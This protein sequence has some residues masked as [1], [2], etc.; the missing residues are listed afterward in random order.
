MDLRLVSRLLGFVALFV[1]V[2]MVF[3]TPWA[4]PLFGA[5]PKFESAGFFG[6]LG[7]IAVSLGSAGVLWRLGQGNKGKLYRKEAM[8]VVGLSWVLATILG[9]IPYLLSG[10]ARGRDDNGTP[11]RM[12]VADALFEAQ[13][14][15]ST[16]GSTVITDLEDRELVPRSILFWRASTQFLGGLGIIVLFVAVLGQG[17]AGKALMRAE[18]TGPTKEGTTTRMQ[19]TAWVFAGIYTLLNGALAVLLLLQGVS[20]FDSLCHAFPTLATGGFSNYNDSIGHFSRMPGIYAPLI[21]ITFIVFMI[22]GGTNFALLYFAGMGRPRRLLA[23]VEWRVYMGVLLL[24]TALVVISGIGNHDF[25]STGEAI[26]YGTFNTVSVITTTGFVN[27]DFDAWNH[28]A[29]GLLFLLMF[30]GACAGSTSGGL[31]L[32]RG[33]LLT[34]IL[35]LEIEQAYR[36]SVVRPLRL[37]GETL[38]DPDLRKNVLLF[39]CLF[40][41]VVVVAWLVL[42]AVEPDSTWHKAGMSADQKF[43]DLGSGIAATMNTVGPGLGIVGATRTYADFTSPTKLIFAFLMLVGRLEL[44]AVLVLFMPRFWMKR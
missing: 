4:L 20:L 32:I 24:A 26:R 43:V 39:T 36:P 2:A 41:V 44:F 27:H 11:V 23:N 33:I 21:E 1:G 7:A 40:L 16:A 31:K 18:M 19:H 9:A 30:V 42:I 29:R 28:F 15:F 14:G 8:A 5:A 37:G 35:R 17:S 10:T 12:N 3:S 22:L 34:K 13:S 38:D 6:L 25:A